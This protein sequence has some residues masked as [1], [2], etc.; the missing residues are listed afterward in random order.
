LTV[1]DVLLR[2]FYFCALDDP[3]SFSEIVL[4][5]SD[6]VMVEVDYPH[7]DSSWPNTQEKLDH[8]IQGSGLS[9][10]VIEQITWRNA[11]ELFHHP[12]P[13]AVQHDP[14]AF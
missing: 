1:R 14:N 7:P 12:V 10:E 3:S 8:Q 4:I 11:S 2:N 9:D 6:R 13:A 5:G